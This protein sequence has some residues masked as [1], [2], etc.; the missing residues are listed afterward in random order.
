MIVEMRTY[1]L[2]PGTLQAALDRIAL[3]LAERTALSSLGAL[4]YTDIG[5][6][7]QIIHLWPYA[8]LADRARIRSRFSTLKN[9]PA[10]TGEFMLEAENK[11]LLPA[12]FSPPLSPRKLGSIYEICIDSLRPHAVR[13]IIAAWQPLIE[14]RTGLSP[15]VGAWSTEFGPMN[16]WIHIWAYESFEQRLAVRQQAAG[17]GWPPREL[18][19]LFDKQESILCF[20][21]DFSPI[22]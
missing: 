21:A 5:R 4:W 10:N 18:T 20:P 12:P 11:I 9:W 2:R 8:D 1:S 17:G 3:G 13:K 7:H 15:L 19:P 22:H 16:Q 14:A 6:L